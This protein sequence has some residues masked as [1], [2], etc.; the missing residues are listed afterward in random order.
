M[1]LFMLA[2]VDSKRLLQ[3]YNFLCKF[4]CI[5]AFFFARFCIFI[6]NDRAVDLQG[7]DV[8]CPECIDRM[9]IFIYT[10]A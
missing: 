6:G 8:D 9:K 10:R 5:F 1:I 4:K 2:F 7:W 3:N